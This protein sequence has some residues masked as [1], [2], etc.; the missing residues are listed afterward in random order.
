ASGAPIAGVAV[1]FSVKVGLVTVTCTATTTSNGVATCVKRSAYLTFRSTP[2][3]YTAK[4][5]AAALYL[6]GTATGAIVY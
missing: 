4:T 6:A 3:T 2:S 5:P 1:T